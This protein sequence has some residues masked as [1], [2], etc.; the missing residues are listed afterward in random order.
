[1]KR[2]DIKKI[3]KPLRW[4]H[5]GITK[6]SSVEKDVHVAE[7]ADLEDSF[8]MYYTINEYLEVYGKKN[9]GFELNMTF[10]GDDI[11]RYMTPPVDGYI[12]NGD[13]IEELKTKA[14]EHRLSLV[15]GILGIKD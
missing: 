12:C 15:C 6:T 9:M 5:I 8:C 2:K 4:E 11:S 3:L 7:V 10:A 14:E 13:S 1:M